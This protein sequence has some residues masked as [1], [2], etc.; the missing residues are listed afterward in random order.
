MND[1]ISALYEEVTEAVCRRF[2][3]KHPSLDDLTEVIKRKW[4]KRLT[5]YTGLPFKEIN[6][7]SLVNGDGIQGHRASM[8][9]NAIERLPK[10]REDS[11]ENEAEQRALK[12]EEDE[13][14]LQPLSAMPMETFCGVMTA[15]IIKFGYRGIRHGFVGRVNNI[16]LTLARELTDPN[17]IRVG[18]L[19]WTILGKCNQ[20]QRTGHLLQVVVFD[21]NENVGVTSLRD[22][23][24]FWISWK[25]LHQ[26]HE[27]VVKTGRIQ[28]WD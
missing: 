21:G 10:E 1:A 6:A 25:K 20:T 28:L 12:F 8:L 26:F 3:Q 22:K 16:I 7:A 4:R 5:C 9:S 13:L 17:Q 15:R 27:V 11:T 18:Y 14:P 24:F 19:F 23:S 2:L